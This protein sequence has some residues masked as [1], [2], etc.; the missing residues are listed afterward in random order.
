MGKQRV[1]KKLSFVLVVILMMG[2]ILGFDT[3][4][5]QA[6]AEV[7]SDSVSDYTNQPYEITLQNGSF[8]T[9]DITGWTLSMATTDQAGYIVKSDAWSRCSFL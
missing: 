2:Q 8:E 4:G 9:G 6:N 5:L 3:S 1:W 7:T